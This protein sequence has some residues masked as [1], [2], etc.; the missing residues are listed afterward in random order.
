MSSRTARDTQFNCLKN[1]KLKK[2]HLSQGQENQPVIPPTPEAVEG[3]AL[4]SR[5]A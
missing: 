2:R 5:K 4:G 3:G 1:K